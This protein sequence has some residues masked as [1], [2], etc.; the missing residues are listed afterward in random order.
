MTSG[1]TIIVIK[2]KKC[3]RHQ[4]KNKRLSMIDQIPTRIIFRINHG[5]QMDMT[6]CFQSR[7][8]ISL[9]SLLFVHLKNQMLRESTSLKRLSRIDQTSHS[10]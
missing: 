3:L 7:E 2:T 4:K 6:T 9:F 10:N 5:S 1:S 8:L